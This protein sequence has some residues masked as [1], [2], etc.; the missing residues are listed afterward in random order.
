MHGKEWIV[1]RLAAADRAFSRRG[2]PVALGKNET[3]VPAYGRGYRKH[4]A[5][6]VQAAAD[7]F[8]MGG[9]LFFRE[10]DSGGDILG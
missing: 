4:R 8:K 5:G 7:M 6:G 10:V 3:A 2:Q 9:Y 1:N